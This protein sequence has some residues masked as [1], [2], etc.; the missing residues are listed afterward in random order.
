MTGHARMMTHGG[1]EPRRPGN[2][3][4]DSKSAAGEP[5]TPPERR[6][7]AGDLPH[8]ASRTIMNHG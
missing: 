1:S 4:A 5:E 8:K 7:Q 3:E 2:E 6:L